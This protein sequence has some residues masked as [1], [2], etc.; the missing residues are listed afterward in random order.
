MKAVGDLVEFGES[1][2]HAEGDAAA[3]GDGVDFVHRGLQQLFEGEEVLGGA[4]LGD[5]VHLCLC[6]VDDLGD[7]LTVGS[8]VTELHDAGT[9]LHEPP[10]NG[11][12]RHDLGVVPGV[13]GGGRRLSQRDQVRRAADALELSAAI[14]LG[15]DGHR[16]GRLTAAVE[17]ENG[18]VDVL[19]CRPVEV[20]RT[21]HLEHVGDGILAQQ[22]AAQ[23]GLFGGHVLWRLSPEVFARTFAGGGAGVVGLSSIVHNCHANR[24]SSPHSPSTAG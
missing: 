13:G 14:Q 22:H 12:L 24:P 10:E 5:L 3:A 17:V 4:S 15:R 21:E 20:A 7:V 8:G 19:V 16:V 1:R 23:H 9:G 18:V 2:R 11:L 6:A